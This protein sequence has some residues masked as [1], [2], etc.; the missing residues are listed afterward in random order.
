MAADVLCQQAD[1]PVLLKINS[2]RQM[3]LCRMLER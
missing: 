1:L 3:A 2:Q